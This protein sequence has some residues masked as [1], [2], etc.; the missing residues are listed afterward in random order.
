MCDRDGWPVFVRSRVSSGLH[1]LTSKGANAEED[2]TPRLPAPEHHLLT[3]HDE[4]SAEIEI[5]DYIDFVAESKDGYVSVAPPLR[6]IRH[7]LS[8]RRSRLPIA[9]AVQTLP[10][11]LPNGRLLARNGLDREQRLV[12]PL[13]AKMGEAFR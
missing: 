4:C 11:V 7:F 1:E 8:Y 12:S 9:T 2:E 6:F 5:S 13:T 10:L 3:R